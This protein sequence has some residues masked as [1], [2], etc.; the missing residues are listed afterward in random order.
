MGR[1]KSW[2]P[3]TTVSLRF[4]QETIAYVE[5]LKKYLT[6]TKS[7]YSTKKITKSV[8]VE[9]AIGH[10]FKHKRDEYYSKTQGKSFK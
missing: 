1:K 5:H 10:Y 9:Q 7:F 4:E 2:P 6:S 3:K 8:V